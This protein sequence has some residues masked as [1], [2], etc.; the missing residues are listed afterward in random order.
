MQGAGSSSAIDDD[1]LN[2]HVL[3]AEGF[4]V[5]RELVG[6]P[7]TGAAAVVDKAPQWSIGY[8]MA[9][10]VAALATFVLGMIVGVGVYGYRAAATFR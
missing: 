8:K 4:V 6:E 10:V 9:V 2:L 3:P 5:V 1:T 7:D